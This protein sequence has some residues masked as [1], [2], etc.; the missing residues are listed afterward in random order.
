LRE[1]PG[2]ARAAFEEATRYDSS[3]QSLFRTT[4]EDFEFE[5]VPL[6]KHQKVLVL[7]GA[8]GRDPAKWTDPDRFDIARRVTASQIGYGAGA[9]S[10][11]AQM[12]AR[13]EGEVFFRA[14]A[15]KVDR[16]EITA[17]PQ[18]RLQPGL[19]G[20]SSLPLRLTRKSRG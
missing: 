10:C 16:I 8:A 2:L 11:V 17:T 3:S 7:I 13:L 14:L 4:L 20:L 1:D 6:G 15:Q 9:H 18:L 5:G 19:R 12:M